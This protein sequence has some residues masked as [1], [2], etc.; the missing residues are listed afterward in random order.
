MWFFLATLLA[1]A[2]CLPV[3]GDTISYAVTIHTAAN[4]GDYGFINFELNTGIG[5]T[6][7]A[8]SA[9]IYGFSGA[10]LNPLDPANDVLGTAAG[11]LAATVTMDN[12][13]FNDY[14]EGLTFGDRIWFIVTLSGSGL[15]LEGHAGATA[16]TALHT[17]VFDSS[18][19]SM[20]FEVDASGDAALVTVQGS[21]IP[22]TVGDVQPVP[23]PGTLS[24]MALVFLA[25]F[26]V[27]RRVR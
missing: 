8:V 11:D 2:F 1:G 17:Y 21:G 26:A 12:S 18:G 16:D 4:N 14:Y 24:C 3:M 27:R 22:I 20:L 15:R 25:A 9:T 6:P 5:G 19:S 23:E 10:V 13:G 7:G